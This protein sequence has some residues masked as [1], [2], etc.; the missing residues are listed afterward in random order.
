MDVRLAATN[1]DLEEMVDEKAFVE[2]FTI[3]ECLSNHH[4]PE[5]DGLANRL[6]DSINVRSNGNRNVEAG[7]KRC[8]SFERGSTISDF[9]KIFAPLFRLQQ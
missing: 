4:S 6:V 1:C 3:V 5:V 9:H 7:L 2:T 8:Q